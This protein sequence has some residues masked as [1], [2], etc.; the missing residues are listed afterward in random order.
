MVEIQ[1]RVDAI[2]WEQN[3]FFLRKTPF[4]ELKAFD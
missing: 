3:Y 4:L 1:I 2:V